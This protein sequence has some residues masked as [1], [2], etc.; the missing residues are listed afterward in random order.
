MEGQEM[1]QGEIGRIG[2]R[3]H[4]GR[5]WNMGESVLSDCSGRCRRV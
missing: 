1:M 2:G 4:G 3:I 5:A